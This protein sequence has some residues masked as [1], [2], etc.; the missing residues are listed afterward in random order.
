LQVFGLIEWE[1][2]EGIRDHLDT[3]LPRVS[4][5]NTD[6][7]DRVVTDVVI[8]RRSESHEHWEQLLDKA[9]G[10]VGTESVKHVTEDANRT[11]FRSRVGLFHE[12]CGG[13][14][15]VSQ[16]FGDNTLGVNSGNCHEQLACTIKNFSLD[17]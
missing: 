9:F 6:T 7:I 3:S 2:L 14:Q 5:E 10:T 11:S 1:R 16:T 8:V 12:S 17:F 4:D 13:R 15:N